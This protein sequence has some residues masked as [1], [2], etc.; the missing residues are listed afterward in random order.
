MII[1]IDDRRSIAVQPFQE[2]TLTGL[3]RFHASV[4]VQMITTQAREDGTSK[5]NALDPTLTECVTA[6]LHRGRSAACLNGRRKPVG[7]IRGHR[8]CQCCLRSHTAGVDHN[9]PKK[10]RWTT[11]EEQ[12]VQERRHGGLAVGTRDTNEIEAMRRPSGKSVSQYRSVLHKPPAEEC[13]PRCPLTSLFV[14]QRRNGACCFGSVNEVPAVNA[15][16]GPCQ[17]YITWSYVATVLNHANSHAVLCPAKGLDI[18]SVQ[19]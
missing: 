13:R 18:E 10:S 2:R 16:T 3:V 4:V 19:E 6:D 17:K 14:T 8:R 9:T 12:M 1:E 7:Y 11:P 15:L 5:S